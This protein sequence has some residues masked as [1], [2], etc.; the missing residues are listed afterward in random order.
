[1]NEVPTR[2]YLRVS[3][4]EGLQLPKARII[5]VCVTSLVGIIVVVIV[6]VTMRRRRIHG[7]IHVVHVRVNVIL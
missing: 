1:M 2:E 5:V 7:R 3:A 6:I 4:H